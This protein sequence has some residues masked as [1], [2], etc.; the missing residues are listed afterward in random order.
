MDC[1]MI[2]TQE[3]NL[4]NLNASGETVNWYFLD[5]V[6]TLAAAFWTTCSLFIED[7]GQPPS[8]ITIVQSRGYECMK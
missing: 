2:D 8:S 3:R 6:R 1:S 5:L 7:A 4:C